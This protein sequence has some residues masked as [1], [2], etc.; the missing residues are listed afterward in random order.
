MSPPDFFP[1]WTDHAVHRA[2]ARGVP[3]FHVH[4]V[5]ANA[6]RDPFIGGGRRALSISR[7]RLRTLEREIPAGVREHLD[8]LAVVI[9]EDGRTIITILH[10]SAKAGRRYR[11][12][13][14]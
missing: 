7:K 9:D 13:L 6:D 8:G 3:K 4:L 2:Q 11:R 10:A 12:G 5:C 1:Y 14:H